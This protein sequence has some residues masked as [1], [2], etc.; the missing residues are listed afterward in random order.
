VIHFETKTT[1]N[2]TVRLLPD[3]IGIFPELQ[4]LASGAIWQ[5]VAKSKPVASAIGS[6]F[7]SPVRLLVIRYSSDCLK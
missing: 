2:W 4:A 3:E 7:I 6:G 1:D 5:I